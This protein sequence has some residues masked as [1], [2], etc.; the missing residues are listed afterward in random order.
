MK[1]LIKNQ[2]VRW[3]ALIPG[4][5]LAYFCGTL[6]INAINVLQ[7]MVYGG[8]P[9]NWKGLLQSGASAYAFVYL[10]AIIA[11]QFK[12]NT[13]VILG[14]L[15]SAA[16]LALLGYVIA[17]PGI[18]WQKIAWFTADILASISGS[19]CGYFVAQA[20]FSEEWS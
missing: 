2:V 15:I 1:K 13:S 5:I 9:D 12:R 11:P 4:V 10:G 18:P 14:T 20:R 17:K 3:I 7:G 16:T 19:L 6:V 8:W